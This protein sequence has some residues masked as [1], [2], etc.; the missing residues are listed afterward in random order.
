MR[1]CFLIKPAVYLV[2]VN[3]RDRLMLSNLLLCG[4]NNSRCNL[5]FWLRWQSSK[6]ALRTHW[7]WISN[8]HLSHLRLLRGLPWI[9]MSFG[10]ILYLSSHH[11]WCGTCGGCFMPH[12]PRWSELRL[13]FSASNEILIY[14]TESR[15]I[16]ALNT[17]IT[18][19]GDE[20]NQGMSMSYRDLIQSLV[21][22]HIWC[23]LFFVLVANVYPPL[24]SL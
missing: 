1:S 4:Y 3:R 13:S 21:S 11:V 8:Y 12:F 22:I 19:F 18:S 2:S 16:K 15:I 9:C 17:V 7:A 5:P 6:F 14:Q 23:F 24:V 20:S 10:Y